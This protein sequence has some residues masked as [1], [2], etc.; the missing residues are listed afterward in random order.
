MLGGLHEFGGLDGQGGDALG[1]GRLADERRGL[2]ARVGHVAGQVAVNAGAIPAG[3]SINAGALGTTGI[4][5]I[6]AEIDTRTDEYKNRV[7]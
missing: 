3:L 1:E 5:D 6:S 2:A 7:K 4:I